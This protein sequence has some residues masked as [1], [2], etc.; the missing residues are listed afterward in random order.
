MKF[1]GWIVFH[2]E[3]WTERNFTVKKKKKKILTVASELL[4]NFDN[5]YGNQLNAKTENSTKP[6]NK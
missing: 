2:R 6:T 4:T 3:K 5:W 1:H